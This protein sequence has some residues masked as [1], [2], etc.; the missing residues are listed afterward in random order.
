MSFPARDLLDLLRNHQDGIADPLRSDLSE[1]EILELLS[2]LVVVMAAYG[3]SGGR[4]ISFARRSEEAGVHILPVNFYSPV[5]DVSR[6]PAAWL[7]AWRAGK[8]FDLR[9]GA[10]RELLAGLGKWAPEL[11]Q[12]PED[13][14]EGGTGFYWNNPTFCRGDASVYYSLIRELRPRRIVEVGCGMST[15][16]ALAA[17]GRNGP[18][19]MVCVEPYPEEYLP[20]ALRE[21]HAELLAV[22]VQEVDDAVFARLGHGD[23]LF[24]DSTHVSKAGSDVN[25]L[26]LRVLPALEPGVVVHFHDIFLPWDMPEEWIFDKRIFWNEQYLLLAFLLYNAEFEVLLANQYLGREHG[27]LFRASFPKVDIPGGASFWIRRKSGPASP[28]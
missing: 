12:F 1:P 10:Q 24:I 27:E 19:A 26:I 15:L 11:E 3:F 25:H 8:G 6:L 4:E 17:A 7:R 2:R 5:P 14:V 23:F 22:P 16:V 28:D 18:T 13:P 21:T 20:A 9:P